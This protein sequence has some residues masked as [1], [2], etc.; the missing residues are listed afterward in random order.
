MTEK[1]VATRSAR[2]ATRDVY[3]G[4]TALTAEKQSAN[5][6][7]RRTV[8]TLLKGLRDLEDFELPGVKQVTAAD[9]H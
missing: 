4:G 3:G 7:R 6:R 8:N 1:F 9:I 5:R 2:R